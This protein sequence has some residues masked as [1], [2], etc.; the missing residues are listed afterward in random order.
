M[1]G[2]QVIRGRKGK[3]GAR[4]WGLAGVMVMVSLL[5]WSFSA[6]AEATNMTMTVHSATMTF[7]VMQGPCPGF[8]AGVVYFTF[9]GIIHQ[10]NDSAGGKHFTF[11]SEGNFTYVQND[12]TK[13]TYT[14]HAAMWFGANV[15]VDSSGVFEIDGTFSVH[16]VGSDGSAI[17]FNSEAH[18]TVTPDGRVTSVVMYFNC[19]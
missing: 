19:H 11:T 18:M 14:G 6:R 3:A 12:P 16:A 13:P 15:M 1:S 7:P 5:A 4:V 9:N 17:N 2:G 8:G 10:T